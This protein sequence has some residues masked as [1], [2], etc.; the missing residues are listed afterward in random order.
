[1]ENLLFKNPVKKTAISI[2][3]KSPCKK[4]TK[5]RFVEKLKF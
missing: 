2:F 1:M 3:Q 4:I 5:N